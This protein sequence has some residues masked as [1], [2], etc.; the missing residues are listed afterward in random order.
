MSAQQQSFVII[1]VAHVILSVIRAAY[2]CCVLDAKWNA[3]ALFGFSSLYF[4]LVMFCAFPLKS[5]W[6]LKPL[7]FLSTAWVYLFFCFHDSNRRKLLVLIA[8]YLS[9]G[10]ADTL[11]VGAVSMLYP[12]MADLLGKSPPFTLCNYFL[13]LLTIAML[14][15]AM[16]LLAGRFSPVLDVK[17][18]LK[19][20]VFPV[21]QIFMLYVISYQICMKRNLLWSDGIL[22]LSAGGVC[23][24][25]DLLLFRTI[26]DMTKRKTAQLQDHFNPIQREYLLSKLDEEQS[27][28]KLLHDIANQIQTIQL[29]GQE[30]EWEKVR[31]Y[32]DQILEQFKAERPPEYCENRI[33]N[34]VLSYKIAACAELGI[35]I[36]NQIA[37]SKTIPVEEMDLISVFANLLDNAMNA[38]KQAAPEHRKIELRSWEKAGFLIVHIENTKTGEKAQGIP[39]RS[40]GLGLI[41]LKDLARKYDGAFSCQDCGDI[42]EATISLRING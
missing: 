38:C 23:I 34:A 7:L 6:L 26:L 31:V 8:D 36:N 35:S 17:M 19:L 13:Y 27:R 25:T 33:I 2:Y 41:I 4:S 1:L 22:M 21:S 15:L 42:F 24:L 5:F 40:G 14:Y 3:K 11:M 39:G 9:L 12:N 18:V 30:K 10:L 32:T 37:L 20:G 29:L 16:T 28:R